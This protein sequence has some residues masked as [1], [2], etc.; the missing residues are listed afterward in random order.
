MKMTRIRNWAACAACVAAGAAWGTQAVPDA[1]DPRVRSYVAPT[2][3]VWTSMDERVEFGTR[4]QVQNAQT[5][6]EAKFGQVPQKAWLKPSGCTLVNNGDPAGVLLDFGRELH[7]GLQVGNSE[8]THGSKVRI[9][10]GESV[11]E[12]M[13]DVGEKG[14]TNDHAVRDAVYELPHLGMLEIGNTGFRF[15][16]ID[17]L[18][19][20]KATLEFVRA[21]S[22]MRPMPRVGAFR[23]SDERLNRVW[24]T[25][26]RTVH[27]CCQDYLWDGIKR[28]RLV[29]M[30]DTHPETRAILAVFGAADVLPAS[31]DYAAATTPPRTAWMNGMANY[32]LWYLRNVHDWYFHTGDAGFLTARRDYLKQTVEHVLE[33]VFG[34]KAAYMTAGFLDWPTQHNKPAVDAGTRGLVATT[35]ENAAT[36]MEVMGEAELAGRCRA[37]VAKVRAERPDP[38]GAK[39]AAA[40][41]ALGG[42]RDAKEMYREVL[43]RN[44]HE[45]VSTFYGYY[46]IEAMS[47]AGE[48]QRALDTVRDYWGAMLDMGAT[49]FWEDF[50]VAWTN[51]ATRLDERPVA[52]KKDIHGDFG[53]FCYPGYR[54]SLC[55]GWS[56]GPAAWCIGHVLGIE[57]VE[58]GCRTVR[59]K[60]FLGDLAWA[61]GAFPT[62]KGAVRVRAEKRADGTLDVKIT[63]PE[64]VRIVRE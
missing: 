52:G 53:E 45:G 34:E 55:H 31:L 63:A 15:V 26:A 1:V 5:L 30:G 33:N 51:N 6:L 32:T 25:A 22:L 60:P 17:L 64:G 48:N 42:L 56:A 62:P 20:G 36:M 58:A 3:V 38:H 37:A 39:S 14:A 2:R 12:A 57:A 59:V 43:G 27:L 50:N 11:G 24:E 8:F 47:A 18:T 23:S 61:E 9:R 21:V 28:D 16:R 41:L 7:G 29:W 10:F 13:S 44:G 19:P 35:L 40:L 4:A 46:M 49:S 54:H